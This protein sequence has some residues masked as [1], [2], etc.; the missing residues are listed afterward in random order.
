MEARQAEVSVAVPTEGD[1]ADGG[2]A[3]NCVSA[4]VSCR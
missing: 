4:L 2:R 1:T 3:G